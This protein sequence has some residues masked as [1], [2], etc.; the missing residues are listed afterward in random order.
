MAGATAASSPPSNKSTAASDKSGLPTMDRLT[1]RAATTADLPFI[2]DLAA[3]D[4]VSATIN[5]WRPEM[6][7]AYEAVLAEIDANPNEA[8]F[9]V[10]HEGAAIGMFQLTFLTSLT[11]PGMWRG[12]VESVHIIPEERNKGFGGEMMR[13]AIA[14]CRARGCGI[15]QLTSNKRRTDAHRFYEALGFTAS[16]EGFRLFL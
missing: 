13:W 4:D 5:A 14:H 16:H 9:V 15:V 1:Y 12:F 11:R 7:G 2:I 8:F 3:A 10:E 6:A